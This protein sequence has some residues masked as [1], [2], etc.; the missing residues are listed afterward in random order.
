MS[1]SV[2]SAWIILTFL[3]FVG[4]TVS[5][6][7]IAMAD[8]DNETSSTNTARNSMNVAIN[9]GN[10]RVNEEVTINEEI[11]REAVVRQYADTASFHDGNKYLNIYEVSSKP[12]MLAVDSYGSVDTPFM[13]MTNNFK[14]EN[15]DTNTITRSREIVIYEAKDLKKE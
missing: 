8:S 3:F 11:A 7:Y 13:N 10:A 15:N 9:W 12:A 2:M 6:Q 14:G 4:F 5:Y 1:N